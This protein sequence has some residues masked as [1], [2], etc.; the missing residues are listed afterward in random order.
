MKLPG[1]CRFAPCLV[2]ALAVPLLSQVAHVRSTTNANHWADD[3]TVT[4]TAWSSTTNY[5]EVS[6]AG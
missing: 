3:G 6:P 5:I 2:M 4:G 1:I